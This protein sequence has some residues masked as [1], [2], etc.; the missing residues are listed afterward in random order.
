MKKHR[1]RL[2]YLAVASLPAVG[3]W[4]LSAHAADQPASA[5]S[6]PTPGPGS[7]PSRLVPEQ[8]SVLFKINDDNPEENVPTAK[9]RIGNPLEF[10]YYIQDLLTRAEVEGKRKNQAGVIKYLRALAAALP[11]E[12]RSWALLCEAYRAADDRDRAVRACKYAIERQGVQFRDYQRYVELMAAK[13]T[14]LLPEERRD[15]NEALGHLDKQP[16]LA[17]P[18]AHL[19]CQAAVKMND[20][21][22]LAACTTVLAKAAPNDPK[23]VVFQWSLAV[24]RGDQKQAAGL[25]ARGKQMGLA[26]AS[27][28]RMNEVVMGGRG[29][30]RI[31]SV[32]RALIVSGV[33]L[34]LGVSLIVVYRRRL[35]TGSRRLAP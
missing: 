1:V 24:M 10:G 22:A 20:E 23:T 19:R 34:L 7:A 15:L 2:I 6:Q 30:W 12:A 21:A 33:A 3:I 18:T 14:D 17:V 5:G 25:L 8:F 4:S 29:W 35:A 26:A 13:P 31:R 28:D 32:A 27:I 11:E 9:D 16:D